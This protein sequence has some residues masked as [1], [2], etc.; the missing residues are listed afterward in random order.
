MEGEGE[1]GIRQEGLLKGSGGKCIVGLL[2]TVDVMS[3]FCFD[4]RVQRH[5]SHD[6]IRFLYLYPFTP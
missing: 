6:T 3:L 5:M 2:V 4:W 1:C